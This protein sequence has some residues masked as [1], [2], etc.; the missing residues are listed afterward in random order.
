MHFWTLFSSYRLHHPSDPKLES[1]PNPSIFPVF[2]YIYNPTLLYSADSCSLRQ[3][4]HC[5]KVQ[6]LQK[7]CKSLC[8]CREHCQHSEFHV[9]LY[10][11]ECKHHTSKHKL[12]PEKKKPSPIHRTKRTKCRQSSQH[13]FTCHSGNYLLSC[14]VLTRAGHPGGFSPCPHCGWRRRTGRAPGP[15]SCRC[16]CRCCCRCRSSAAPPRNLWGS[17]SHPMDTPALNSPPGLS[18]AARGEPQG[19][20]QITPGAESS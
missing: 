12:I 20:A 11:Y 19:W 9:F 4:N 8:S 10:H 17:H 1:L 7:R 2:F 18:A 6:L 3:R 13:S 14:S 15:R 16:R 5:P